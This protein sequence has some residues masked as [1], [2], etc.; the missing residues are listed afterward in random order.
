MTSVAPVVE[1][2]NT[3]PFRFACRISGGRART[4]DEWA[5][6]ARRA[7]TLGFASFAVAEHFAT[8]YAPL[9]Y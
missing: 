1:A 2:P 6:T 5:A 3:K 7:E 9:G 4:A 8:Q